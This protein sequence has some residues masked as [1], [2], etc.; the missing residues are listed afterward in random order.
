MPNTL[1]LISLMKEQIYI[2][3][4]HNEIPSA[5]TPPKKHLIGLP[6]GTTHLQ[7]GQVKLQANSLCHVAN[8]FI[9]VGL[10]EGT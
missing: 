5:S 7:M 8:L 9:Y 4:S 2:Y 10:G 3:I 1:V 6:C